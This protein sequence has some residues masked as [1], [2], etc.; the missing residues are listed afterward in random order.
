[1]H[2]AVPL[3]ERVGPRCRAQ[4][5]LRPLLLRVEPQVLRRTAIVRALRCP[6]CRTERPM[7]EEKTQG[8]EEAAKTENHSSSPRSILLVV[9]AVM[10]GAAFGGTGVWWNMHGHGQGRA[11]EVAPSEAKKAPLY[12]CPMH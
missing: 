5:R 10:V 3:V 8:P 7:G 12:R 2:R 4:V 11:S 6:G 1:M 9:A